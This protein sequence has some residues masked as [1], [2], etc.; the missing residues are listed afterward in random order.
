MSNAKFGAPP[1]QKALVKLRE[2][3][4]A[5]RWDVLQKGLQL[6]DVEGWGR[7]RFRDIT[8]P[9]RQLAQLVA[10]E[11]QRVDT[12]LDHIYSTRQQLR[13]ASEE[14]NILRAFEKARNG[15]DFAATEEIRI[16]YEEATR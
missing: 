8:Q 1:T 16:A 13:G 11:P 14:A 3:L 7:G 10:P 5:W 2:M 4:L 6:P 9:I 15:A 12:A